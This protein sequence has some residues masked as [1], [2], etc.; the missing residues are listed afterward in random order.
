MKEQDAEWGYEPGRG[1]MA[2]EAKMGMCIV[3]ILLCAFSFLV[4]HKYDLK[5]KALAFANGAGGD[6]TAA[7]PETG[8]VSDDRFSE[9]NPGPSKAPSLA[10]TMP[11]YSAAPTFA[12]Q[13]SDGPWTADV[14]ETDLTA[15]DEFSLET[16]MTAA[17]FE[18]SEPEE[19]EPSP[20]RDLLA[21]REESPLLQE[22]PTASGRQLDSTF[23]AEAAKLNAGKKADAF[24][25]FEPR[26]TLADTRFDS[27]ADESI[28]AESIVPRHKSEVAV[29]ER[30][31]LQP[32]FD[33]PAFA[34]FDEP[35]S[36]TAE[37]LAEPA[38]SSPFPDTA[39]AFK[40][41][42]PADFAAENPKALPPVE[43]RIES[44]LAASD[45]KNLSPL[46]AVGFGPL[47]TNDVK[48]VTPFPEPRT[49][50]SFEPQPK[51]AADVADTTP[52]PP[53]PQPFT[54]FEPSVAALIEDRTPLR[55]TA[56]MPA[57]PQSEL[58]AKENLLASQ[59]LSAEARRDQLIAMTSPGP[60]PDVDVFAPAPTSREFVADDTPL[61]K[62][63]VLQSEP[64]NLGF[65]GFEPQPNTPLPAQRTVVAVPSSDPFS[66]TDAGSGLAIP[67]SQQAD[68]VAHFT[69]PPQ[70][71]VQ[72]VS[73]ISQECDI[74]EVL[75]NDNYWRISQRVYGT[76]QYFS[77]LALYN[78]QRIPDPKK[79]RPGMKVLIPDPK[80]LE[81]KYPE[82]FK[83]RDLEAKP[84]VGYFLKSDGNP[85]YRIGER[86]TLSEISQKH[87]GRA[88]RWIQI[89][90]MNQ[91]ILK[92]PNK[93]K[94]GTVIALPDDATNV[95][96]AP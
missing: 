64:S 50:S 39:A 74:C 89:Y 90:R 49:F 4:Y 29:F 51:T 27:S 42:P 41:L 53:I 78:R 73:G 40:P 66:G 77:S 93:L 7:G 26:D 33:E 18:L 71:K 46:A 22:P 55:H 12:G 8:N 31:S 61:P 45:I 57:L 44:Q 59:K 67:Q 72:Q 24:D 10:D 14:V 92:D 88:S 65:G 2:V 81:E 82:F 15:A 63:P 56:P 79:L 75:P 16:G 87:L 36:K 83:D 96:L 54:E 69:M 34:A 9:L 6:T 3:A 70:R 23:G 20:A 47:A 58:A 35:K 52:Q 86:E 94:P 80:L 38:Q 25:S 28:P 76:S 13:Q 85:A 21:A 1:G 84:A 37:P 5:Q 60:A 43:K 91:H 95:H 62:K 32:V 17:Q 30:T 19:F 68:G 11:D 48:P